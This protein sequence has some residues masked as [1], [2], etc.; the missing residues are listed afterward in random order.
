MKKDYI[1]RRF[2][3]ALLN[4]QLG[5]KY[6]PIVCTS[7]GQ[8]VVLEAL[9]DWPELA[10]F[11]MTVEELFEELEES[12][13]LSKLYDRY[14]FELSLRDFT[15][16]IEH[17]GYNGMISVNF[18][19]STLEGYNIEPFVMQTLDIYPTVN[20]GRVMIEITER[21]K[22]HDNERVLFN[23]KGL[24]KLGLSIALDDFM[25]GFAN[26]NS[27]LCSQV[28]YVKIGQPFSQQEKCKAHQ[29]VTKGV[30]ELCTK[31]SKQ[32]IVEG[33]ETQAELN[34]FKQYGYNLFQGYFF[35][36]PLLL[37]EVAC[38]LSN[39]KSLLLE[40]GRPST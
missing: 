14:A 24:Q 36:K 12:P 34:Y 26:F 16:L 22:W 37:E 27:L 18:C 1:L 5:L 39:A 4:H 10:G 13:V 15:L 35:S 20:W 2:S 7:T 32:A 30:L 28:N 11:G 40:A 6:Q 31:V 25:T 23:L 17:S 29:A 9:L 19:A 8:V 33:I 38:Y 21:R 3:D